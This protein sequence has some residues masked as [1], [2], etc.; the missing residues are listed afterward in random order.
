MK[1]K[2]L[3]P[4]KKGKQIV[5]IRFGI[6]LQYTSCKICGKSAQEHSD[7]ITNVR[8]AAK[9]LQEHEYWNKK[10]TWSREELK[11]FIESF[12]PNTYQK[13]NTMT[14]ITDKTK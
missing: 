4:F 8:K 6:P 12:K 5:E 14:L 11:E 1:K 2:E 3:H 10:K 7:W 9:A 13:D